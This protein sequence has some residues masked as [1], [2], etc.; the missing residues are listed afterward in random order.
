MMRL[1]DRALPDAAQRKLAEYQAAIDALSDYEARVGRAKTSFHSHN[2]KGDGAFDAV[3][4]VLT[5]MCS[6][7]RRCAY[8]EDSLADE[9]EHIWPKD[10][11]PERAFLWK[12]Y[13]YACG[14]CNGP[15]NN[16]F[17]VFA[18]GSGVPTEVARCKG[19]AIAPPLAGEPVLL[20]PRSEDPCEYLALDLR[21]TFW[22]TP[23]APRGT[24]EFERATYTIKVLRLNAND[25]LPKSRQQ[26]Y[27]DY[28][29]HL[30]HYR[31][32][33]GRNA[34]T[35]ELDELAR[36]VGKRQQP[37]V[38]AEMKRQRD[39]IPE[40]SAMFDAVPEALSW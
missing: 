22:F 7:A 32:M 29:A 5:A 23:R 30:S 1:A 33:Q 40:L 12:N 24:R 38:W 36:D 16:H 19:S 11:Y 2:R 9:V 18:A 27:K 6:G 21:D 17:A 34:E 26:A 39:Y 14:P 15:K 20:D 10:L 35:H 13:V 3:K 8:C 31:Q 37:T 25:A 4:D 28:R